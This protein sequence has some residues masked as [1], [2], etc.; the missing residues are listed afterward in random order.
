MLT[1]TTTELYPGIILANVTSPA[2][3]LLATNLTFPDLSGTP[4]TVRVAS[5]LSAVIIVLGISFQLSSALSFLQAENMP[6][7]NANVAR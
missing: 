1:G 3:A 6:M 5:P 2:E 4:F 7:A